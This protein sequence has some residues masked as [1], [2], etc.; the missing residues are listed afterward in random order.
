MSV[1]LSKA[2]QAAH[3]ALVWSPVVAPPYVRHFAAFSFFCFVSD[4]LGVFV[5]GSPY[6]LFKNSFTSILSKMIKC[7]LVSLWKRLTSHCSETKN[8]HWLE[9][10]KDSFSNGIIDDTKKTLHILCFCI[11]LSVF[12]SLFHQQHTTW[13]FESLRTSD[14]LI[15]IPFKVYMLQVVNPLLVLFTITYMNR[16]TSKSMKTMW[17]FCVA[18]GN[19][20]VIFFN[21]CVMFGKKSNMFAFIALLTIIVTSNLSN[22]YKKWYF[23][24]ETKN[25]NNRDNANLGMLLQ[26]QLST[27][28]LKTKK[29]YSRQQ[30]VNNIV[31]NL[32]Y[33]IIFIVYLNLL[34]YKVLFKIKFLKITITMKSVL[35]AFKM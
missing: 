2:Q 22:T 27:I 25:E 12:W 32:T 11:P 3:R 15:V 26:N 29:L 21:K 34:V 19:L 16:V 28:V 23:K 14:H 5:C 18:L 30:S 8:K 13:I 17:Y 20:A 1:W 9:L 4:H 24:K 7:I 35:N 10:A 6:Y 33:V 31:L